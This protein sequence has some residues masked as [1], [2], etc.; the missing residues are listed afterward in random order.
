MGLSNL[1]KAAL[2]EKKM[3]GERLGP[4][5]KD[6]TPKGQEYLSLAKI[7]RKEGHSIRNI[8]TLLL[9]DGFKISIGTLVNVF[10]EE[11]KIEN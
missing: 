9:N 3:N 8:Q 5:R 11:K 10:K 4:P 1:V 2:L 6:S 7:L